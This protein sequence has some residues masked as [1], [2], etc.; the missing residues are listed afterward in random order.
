M[1]T[2]DFPPF[3]RSRH[4]IGLAKDLFLLGVIGVAFSTCA[5]VN[6]NEAPARLKIVFEMT[7]ES[8]EAFGALV[9][10]LEGLQKNFG[11]VTDIT[12]VASS[13]G[14]KLYKI[15][16][17]VLQ[18]RLAKLA[19]R[20]VDFIACEQGLE[21]AA[22]ETSDLLAFVRTVRSGREEVDQLEKQGWARV[23]SGESYVSHL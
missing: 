2:P 14:V 7:L 10:D 12:V 11:E 8:S 4:W 23:R 16:G 5:P 18:P 13:E 22:M 9:T 17:N 20:G 3:A 21:E 1:S 19:D 6:A 15:A